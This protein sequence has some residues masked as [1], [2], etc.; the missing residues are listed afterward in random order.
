MKISIINCE[1]PSFHNYIISEF[2]ESCLIFLNLNPTESLP[3]STYDSDFFIVN[4]NYNMNRENIEKMKQC[5][6]IIR[7]GIGYDNIDIV[8]ARSKNIDV[9]NVSDYCINE[10]ADHTIALL[11]TYVR[12]MN[13][14]SNFNYINNNIWGK[15]IC[16]SM[17]LGG[18]RIGI[19]GMGKIG[20]AVAQ[21]AE[22]FG[23]IVCYYD[24][25]VN[26]YKNYDC[27][28][29]IND[30]FKNCNI[31]SVHVPANSETH[32]LICNNTMG[33]C[34]DVIL[35]NTSRGAVIN[36]NDVI[37]GLRNNKLKAYL[38]DVLDKEP[39][40]PDNLFIRELANGQSQIKDKIL[41]TPHIAF[42]S[43]ESEQELSIKVANMIKCLQSEKKEFIPIN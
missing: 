19:I 7:N 5:K 6:A 15:G 26:T 21:R 36:N 35:I 41:I 4:R 14:Y 37:C 13:V 33:N 32:M 12:N 20:K 10:V 40:S 42:S 38:T 39:P 2:S 23:M 25:Y 31:V 17:R 1:N 24:P 27:F 9:Y 29:S 3:I 11:L 16:S 8:F 18:K 34:K 43:L 28:N 30:L 22:S